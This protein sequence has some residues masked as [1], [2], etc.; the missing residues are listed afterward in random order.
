MM[1]PDGFHSV[2]PYIF[3]KDAKNLI[4]FLQ[5]SFGAK[6]ILKSLKEDGKVLNAIVRIGDTSFMVADGED[7][8]GPM[9]SSFCLYVENADDTMKTAIANGGVMDMPVEDRPYG[10]RQ[11]GVVDP[12]GNIWWISQRL[13]TGPYS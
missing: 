3:A 2:T 1:I 10:D 9:K 13:V 4:L 12:S 5:N 7:K 8:Y 11:G 6:E